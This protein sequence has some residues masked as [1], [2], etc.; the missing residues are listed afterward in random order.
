MCSTCMCIVH[1]SL[2]HYHAWSW[3]L[4][5][6]NFAAGDI[7]VCRRRR[8]NVVF[9]RYVALLTLQCQNGPTSAV[10]TFTI[11]TKDSL[12]L[13]WNGM[14]A[15]LRQVKVHSGVIFSAN[16]TT[17]PF[18]VFYSAHLYSLLVLCGRLNVSSFPERIKIIYFIINS[19]FS[20]RV[21][22]HCENNA[23][24]AAVQILFKGN[25]CLACFSFSSNGWDIYISR[26]KC[27]LCVRLSVCLIVN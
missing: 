4:C 19:L 23:S 14:V 20:L 12:S 18:F 27:C 5:S 8:F 1:H 25:D 2:N 13:S 17:R 6:L 22:R 9:S 3:R 11:I 21:L 15:R 26:S 24:C 7:T 10:S 16:G